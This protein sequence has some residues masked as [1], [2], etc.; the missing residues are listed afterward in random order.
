[1][2][3]PIL[4]IVIA[5]YN[6]GRYLEDAIQSVITQ[7]MGDKIELIICD[8]AST[9]NS[10]EVIKRYA[11]GL[12][13]NTSYDEWMA[14]SNS[15]LP[16]L[17]SHIITWWCSEPDKGQSEAFNKGFYH[18]NGDW[19]TW[20]NADEIYLPGTLQALVELVQRKPNAHWI[21]S[22]RI[23]FSDA[24]KRITHLTWGPH[25]QMRLFKKNR[26]PFSVFGPTSFFRREVYQEIGPID[27]DLHYAMDYDYWAR[28]TMAGYRQFRLNRFSWAFRVHDESKTAGDISLE[29]KAKQDSELLY[30][31][32][33]SSYSY[34]FSFKNV[35]YVMWLFFRLFD[36]SLFVRGYMRC[37]YVNKTIDELC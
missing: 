3:K 35:W 1:M 36:G 16:V 19:L 5:N 18:A 13:P 4:S 27:E 20:L 9:D 22:N 25:T 12:P 37:K 34:E 30:L 29:T 32:R 17:S 26:A 2:T 31:R 14:K 6:Y 7:N 8:A 24:T 33:K 11:D 23:S 21:T 10:V 28:L 15:Q